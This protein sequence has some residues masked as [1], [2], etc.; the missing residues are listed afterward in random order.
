MRLW[1]IIYP[2]YSYQQGRKSRYWL[3]NAKQRLAG[4]PTSLRPCLLK[5]FIKLFPMVSFWGFFLFCGL[6][7]VQFFFFFFFL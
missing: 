7:F 2:V 3:Q 4:N 6:F 5:M 1:D